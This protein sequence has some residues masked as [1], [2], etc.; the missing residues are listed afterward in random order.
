LQEYW[1]SQI[2]N[3]HQMVRA[4]IS[5][6]QGRRDE[7]LQMLRAA[8]DR[9]DST[10]ND[11][12]MPGHLISA[13]ELVG[14]QLMEMNEPAQALQAFEAALK[15]EPSRFWTLFRG[16]TS[17]RPCRRFGKGEDLFHAARDADG[18]R[19][20]RAPGAERGKS[21]SR[22]AVMRSAK[23]IHAAGIV[24]GMR[25][26]GDATLVAVL[27]FREHL[28]FRGTLAAVLII[29]RGKDSDWEH[30]ATEEPEHDRKAGRNASVRDNLLQR[31]DQHHVPAHRVGW[32]RGS[33]LRKSSSP[34]VRSA[35]IGC[36]A[37]RMVSISRLRQT[38]MPD[39]ARLH[40]IANGASHVFNR[41]RPIDAVLVKEIDLSVRSRLSAAFACSP[42]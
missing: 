14:D 30:H 5:Y 35:V 38:E 27:L 9:E 18:A 36:P 7:A 32:N 26:L 20:P 25:L 13:R 31:T 16:S 11:P 15:M 42:P 24:M 34:N 29:A 33:T 1:V 28:G 21:V 37:R 12:V 23:T 3:H 40:Q 10:E 6:T 41:H 17:G 2:Q 19:R 8:A 4:W 39:L 22:T